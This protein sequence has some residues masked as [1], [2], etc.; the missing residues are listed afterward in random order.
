MSKSNKSRVTAPERMR[1]HQI[2]EL[3]DLDSF[4]RD[5]RHP[6]PDRYLVVLLFRTVFVVH[7]CPV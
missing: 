7:Q 3:F 1:C 4:C 2:L 5:L 6:V